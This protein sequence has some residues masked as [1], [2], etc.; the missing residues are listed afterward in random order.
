MEQLAQN[1][2]PLERFALT[3]TQV[4]ETTGVCRSSL[5]E[6][7]RYGHLRAIKVGR[8]TRI[9]VVDLQAWLAS[10]PRIAAKPDAKTRQWA[11]LGVLWHRARLVGLTGR[12][13]RP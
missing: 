10:R 8:S 13:S 12:W 4:V 6:E 7:I 11:E 3:I 9:R 5:Y 2:G 1:R